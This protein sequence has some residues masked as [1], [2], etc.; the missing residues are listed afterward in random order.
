MYFTPL[1]GLRRHPTGPD[2]VLP[3]RAL[4]AGVPGDE[5][6]LHSEALIG[7]VRDGGLSA[8]TRTVSRSI[9]PCPSTT[10][11]GRGRTFTVAYTPHEARGSVTALGDDVVPLRVR[12]AGG[13]EGGQATVTV[14]GRSVGFE[15][16]ATRSAS[17][18]R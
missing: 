8:R 2:V 12:L 6:L 18:F 16:E 5:R 13:A 3:R 7:S 15:P 11:N 4:H 14:D 9:P 17:T 1:D 10:S